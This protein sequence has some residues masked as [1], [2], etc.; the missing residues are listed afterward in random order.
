MMPI[1]RCDL[2]AKMFGQEEAREG[3]RGMINVDS[4]GYELNMHLLLQS[5]IRAV[6]S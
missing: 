6:Q 4:W 2:L 1:L 3:D 5:S